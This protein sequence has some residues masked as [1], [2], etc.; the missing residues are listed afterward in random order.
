M[1]IRLNRDNHTILVENDIN[2]IRLVIDGK[3]VDE[4][5]GH[6]DTTLTG[7]VSNNN[8]SSTIKVVFELKTFKSNIDVYYNNEK[9]YTTED[10]NRHED[11]IREHLKYY[12]NLYTRTDECVLY[13]QMS[14]NGD[15]QA[16]KELLNKIFKIIFIGIAF[17]II[18]NILFFGLKVLIPIIPFALIFLYFYISNKKSQT[19]YITKLTINKGYLAIS[20]LLINNPKEELTEKI[21]LND[22]NFRYKIYG[23]TNNH[24]SYYMYNNYNIFKIDFYRKKEK[25]LALI[26]FLNHLKNVNIINS[27]TDNDI[28][29]YKKEYLQ[30]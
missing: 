5:N 10:T 3:M 16:S 9:I 26:I 20:Y 18:P 30:I 4:K 7:Y 6:Y 14:C 12:Y 11:S 15:S 2:G 23:N 17:T 19:R 13:N 22:I 8:I 29:L 27:L 25:F 21:M 28:L 1:N 24:R